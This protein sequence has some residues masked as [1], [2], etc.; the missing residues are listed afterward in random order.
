MV[1]AVKGAA[2]GDSGYLQIDRNDA[3]P[4]AGFSAAPARRQI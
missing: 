1:M 2:Q 4:R 3:A